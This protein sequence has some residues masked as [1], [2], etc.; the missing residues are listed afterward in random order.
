LRQFLHVFARQASAHGA[1]TSV[2]DIPTIEGSTDE[3]RVAQNSD[4]NG[5][6]DFTVG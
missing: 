5:Y 4:V 3:R 2:P 6:P 1:G